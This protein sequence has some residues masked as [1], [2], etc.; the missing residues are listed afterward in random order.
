MDTIGEVPEDKLLQFYLD[1]VEPAFQ[2]WWESQK[3]A[4]A[5]PG[6]IRAM[7]E[8]KPAA[9][10]PVKPEEAEGVATPQPDVPLVSC[11]RCGQLIA[12]TINPRVTA[13]CPRCGA[14]L[15][16]VVIP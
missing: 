2:R 6:G 10:S 1:Q 14:I 12:W 9:V 3:Q 15:R 5:K 13:V 7:E 4:A 8:G 16:L 11:F